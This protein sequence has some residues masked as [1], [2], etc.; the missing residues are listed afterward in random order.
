MGK[1]SN[2]LETY[3][4]LFE[5]KKGS[6]L[7]YYSFDSE[8]NV[9]VKSYSREE[10]LVLCRRAA[11][12]L[13]SFGIAKGDC[14]LHCFS[15]N[16]VDDII[17]RTA[18]TMIGVI[19]VTVNWQADTNEQIVYKARVTG[20]SLVI[21]DEGFDEDTLKN[22]KSVLD[23]NVF[24]AEK[25]CNYS[26]IEEK[27][28]ADLNHSDPKIV[29]F[30]SG[31]TGRPKGVEL[32]YKAYETNRMTFE[33]F[34]NI[35]HEDSLAVILVN[36]MY[37]TNSS[38]IVDWALRKPNSEVHLVERYTSNY[39]KLLTDIVEMNYDRLVA[40]LVSK[41][42]SFLD[43]LY[44]MKQ[45]PVG[46]DILQNRMDKVDFLL[47]SA[48]VGP[49]TLRH[50]GHFTNK[51][52]LVRFGSTETCLQVLGIPYKIPEGQIMEMFRKG[53]EH[54]YNEE[55]QPGYYI[56]RPHPPH[57]E[58]R[59]VKSISLEDKNFMKDCE[60][61]E[62]GYIVTKGSNLMSKYVNEP[63]ATE[64]VFFDSWYT[65][66]KD[67][68]FYLKGKDGEPDYFWLSRDSM[69]L[70]KGGVNYSYEQIN[71]EL[72][73]FVEV[74]YGLDKFDFDLAV[75]G[76]KVDSEYEDSC[77]V[78]IDLKNEKA[79]RVKDEIEKSFL[80]EAC[81]RVS[82]GSIPEFL[83][84]GNIPKNFKGAVEV[85]KLEEE[86]SKYLKK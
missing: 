3:H 10:F 66:L 23:I 42:F 27:Y 63:E 2:V 62:P 83:R 72:I 12:V 1:I 84:F 47:G 68:C 17:F 79:L 46:L 9:K 78:T 53:W 39:W 22:L 65:G 33:A 16:S 36:P 14:V 38:A 58:I 49:K 25:L 81:K 24:Y 55:P 74:H 41:H 19:P 51:M 73:S 44:K 29:I 48:P 56:G 35:K 45:L 77:C 57:T 28:I 54:R 75:V 6:F 52:P 40:P 13:K 31:T 64:A 67:I 7:F 15:S 61:G 80:K 18:A 8:K 43:N 70:I 86:F 82:K 50:V 21:A 4:N 60:E 85:K 5:E 11:N 69:L 32:S 76:L 34:L 30:T 37:H 59:V 71:N 26:C 20:C